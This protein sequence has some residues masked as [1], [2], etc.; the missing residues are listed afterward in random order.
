MDQQFFT[1]GEVAEEIGLLRSQF[2]YLV[3][4]GDLPRPS[5]E[6]PGRRLFTAADLE[7]IKYILKTRK[8]NAT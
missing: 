4:H 8:E 5:Y 1:S 2:L 3:E 7:T 6:V